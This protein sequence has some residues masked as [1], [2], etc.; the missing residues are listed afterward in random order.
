MTG[1]RVT[2]GGSLEIREVLETEVPAMGTTAH[3][4]IVDG[5]PDALRWAAAE[6]GRLERL[7]SRFL[8]DSEVSRINR[9]AGSPVRVSVETA[10]VVAAAVSAAVRTGGLFHPLV[11]RAVRAVGYD[12]SFEQ[13]RAGAPPAGCGSPVP[14]GALPEV[15]TEAVTVRIPEG[16]ALDLGGIAKGWSADR[17]W[18]G[19]RARAAGA[20]VNIGGD[21]RCGGLPP[22]PEWG[23]VI[24]VDH[25]PD[26]AWGP[27]PP[28]MAPTGGAH[29]DLVLG[30]GGGAVATSTVTR[31]W[32]T[33]ADGAVRHHLVDPRTGEPA[34]VA[35][36]SATV[37]APVAA[38]AEVTAKVILLGG[39]PPPGTA[40][41][42]TG[43]DGTVT[44]RGPL[45]ARGDMLVLVPAHSPGSV[46]EVLSDAVPPPGG[47]P[48]G[49]R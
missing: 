36:A 33:G 11:G 15:D 20:V 6:L 18:R 24:E 37:V 43:A 48:E 21:L 46:P 27:P 7:L 1:I 13:V 26:P 14:I 16:T 40:A 2:P 38:E 17:V 45:H 49:V 5:D 23:W 25:R 32:W 35:S 28:G 30:P 42:L 41:L 47:L 31:R 34:R 3:L 4:L 8:V 29:V 22:D 19:L 12:R 9:A 39:D 44:V 10:E